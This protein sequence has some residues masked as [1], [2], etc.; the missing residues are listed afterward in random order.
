MVL[1]CLALPLL[2]E[3]GDD[4]AEGDFPPGDEL[5]IEGMGRG[6]LSG[7]DGPGELSAPQS[8][9]MFP[10][11]FGMSFSVNLDAKV[12]RV[13]PRWGMYDKAPSE[14]LTT[15]TGAPKRVWK[16]QP[17]GGEPLD[18]PL[19]AGPIKPII[20]DDAFPDAK[21]K[22]LIRRRSNHWSVTLFLVNEA[23]EPEPPNRE[24]TWMFQCELAAKAPDGAAIF[25]KRFNRIDLPGTDEAFTRETEMLAMLY[26]RHVE[27]VVGHGVGVH[28]DVDLD[29]PNRAVRV[30][31]RVI[32]EYEIPKTTPPTT[33]D[34]NENPAFAKLDGLVLDMKELCESA[35]SNL[36]AQLEPLT[37]AYR[38]WIDREKTKIEDPSE[39][40]APF[41]AAAERTIS[42]C[43][44][45]L[46]RIRAGIDLVAAD[47]QVF[48]AFQFMNQAMWWQRTRTI[49]SEQVRRRPNEDVDYNEIDIA[50]NRSWYPFQLAFILLNLPSIAKLDH[51]ERSEQPDAVADLLWFP[52]GGGKTEA[53]LGL[54]AFTLGIRRLEGTV[55]GRS[56]EDGVAVLMRYTLRLL[57][58]QQF[59]RATA[60]ICAC[61]VIRKKAHDQGDKRWGATPFRIGLWVGA[62]STP[63]KTIH[64][65]EALKTAAGSNDRKRFGAIGGSGSPHQLT[66]CPWCGSEIKFSTPR[67]YVVE[68]PKKGRGRTFVYCGDK[69]G[70]CFFSKSQYKDEG[71]PILVVDEEI[72]RR[73]PSL[74]IATVDKFAQMPWKGETQMLFGQVD[75]RCERHGFRSPEIDDAGSHPKTRDGRFPAAKTVP[76]NPL[77]PPDL[78]I[79]DELHLISGP[80]GTLVGLYETAIDRLCAWTVD[81]KIVRP[82]LI[83]STA[84]IRQAKDQVHALFMRD[85][86]V[87]PPN[88]LDVRDNF[89]SLQRPSNEDTP[90]R[91]Y[92]GICAPGRRLK[93][94]LIRVYVAFLSAAQ[95]LY[96]K[97]GEA[98][99]P[100]MTLVGY[101]NSLRELGGMRRLVDDDV[102][103]RLGKMAD[104]GL[105]KRIIYSPDSVR[106]LTSRL[107]STA[108]PETL[109]RLENIFDPIQEEKRKEAG[110]TGKRPKDLKPRPLD[111]MLATNMIS[112]GVDVPRLGLMVCSGQPK[113]T[114]EYI[115]AT[116]RVG[117]KHP[118]LVITVF[119]WARPRDLSH[120]ETF[121]HYHSTFYQHVEALSV[122]PFSEGA[123]YRGL[124]ALLVAMV[125]LRSGDFNANETA[126]RLATD[127]DHPFVKEA[128]EWIVERARLVGDDEIAEKVAQDLRDKVNYWHNRAIRLSGGSRLGYEGKKDSQTV[129]LLRRPG[130]ESWDEYTCL[131]SLRDVE[132]TSYLVL[133]DHNL[134]DEGGLWSS[135]CRRR[136]GM[137]VGR[138]KPRVGE[139]RP[140]Q[141]LTTFGIGSIVDLPH[142]SAMVMGLEDW[143]ASDYREITEER[144]LASVRNA[145]GPQVQQLRSPPIVPDTDRLNP[146]EEQ[147]FVGVPVAPF[148]RWMLCP[149]CRRL[150]PLS[151]NQFMLND[152]SIPARSRALRPTRIADIPA[153][154]RTVIPARFIVACKNGHLDDFPW[155]RIRAWGTFELC[156]QAATA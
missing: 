81:G 18:I 130:I 138:E 87:F 21:V 88:G 32:P 96:E 115:Q 69:F 140:S 132:P 124:A 103:T 84:T 147:S 53:Y 78:I 30:S 7:D 25:H 46:E 48:E 99:D 146:F 119:N 72:Y 77:R 145:L 92:L 153:S 59:Q 9:A 113:T 155:V 19:V 136:R 8:K 37:A 29:D 79:Q 65:E 17:C 67:Y 23:T 135:Q 94:A 116:S 57:T 123:T 122:T 112:V 109:D 100:W 131:N 111:V 151:S 5:A 49:F 129:G 4:Y 14:F 105:A 12:L 45:T 95:V 64:S 38:E 42:H 6:N 137:S 98:A 106:E 16:R 33:A 56:G 10:S 27:F 107:G 2:R 34:A 80:L 55:E 114:S 20:A 141:I 121:E 150:A 127:K 86:N 11:S 31:T 139:L 102:R 82:K 118:G 110:K 39:R 152:R 52:T 68:P 93:L 108:I 133:D 36:H 120:Y 90:G 74:L 47:K 63:N 97:Y 22:G 89:F 50:K 134:D 143:P 85:T 83:A 43:Q 54:T 70:Q 62:S 91:K 3:S 104:R 66:N 149:R 128:V 1:R 44:K 41:K 73:L 35:Q 40:L 15:K 117:R 51:P 28:A 144:L 156:V 76:A 148:P 126:M 154:C 75:G 58:L 60:L 24:R 125:R 142:I 101:F 13:T 71:I 26:R 61:E